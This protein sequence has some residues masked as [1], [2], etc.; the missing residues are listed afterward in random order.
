MSL[1]RLSQDTYN[2]NKHV[3]S[4]VFYYFILIIEIKYSRL[5]RVDIEANSLKQ[6]AVLDSITLCLGRLKDDFRADVIKETLSDLLKDE[7]PA[8]PIMR[9]AILS[10]QVRTLQYG[11]LG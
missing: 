9:T 5:Y 7:I 6:K 10:S 8:Q 11:I 4:D 1:S 2:S 3:S